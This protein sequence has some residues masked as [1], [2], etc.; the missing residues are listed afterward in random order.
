MY[1][2]LYL[3][4]HNSHLASHLGELPPQLPQGVAGLFV[5][6]EIAYSQPPEGRSEGDLGV[7]LGEGLPDEPL[8]VE[9]IVLGGA[10]VVV[11]EDLNA[12]SR[13][14][15]IALVA[16]VLDHAFGPAYPLGQ[17]GRLHHFH[18]ATGLG[19]LEVL[20]YRGVEDCD[21]GLCRRACRSYH[22]QGQYYM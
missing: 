20:Y 1:L 17:L 6:T 2:Y 10:V 8:L 4:A 19:T 22:K 9:G 11:G 14:L 13:R 12:E 18:F 3:I 5:G 16:V 21:L 7:Q 15:G